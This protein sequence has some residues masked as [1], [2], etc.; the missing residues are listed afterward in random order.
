[1]R[2]CDSN[3]KRRLDFSRGWSN[4]SQVALATDG[5]QPWVERSQTSRVSDGW[6]TAVGGAHI[7][8]HH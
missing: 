1:M 8:F 6:I 7:Y 3:S 2:F 4:D 5:L